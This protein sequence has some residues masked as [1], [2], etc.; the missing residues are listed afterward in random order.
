[1]LGSE[2]TWNARR[3]V[4]II[5]VGEVGCSAGNNPVTTVLLATIESLVGQAH[6]FRGTTGVG[7]K[8]GDSATDG[9]LATG[10]CFLAGEGEAFDLA[11][12]LLCCDECSFLVRIMEDHQELLATE[13]CGKII[14]ADGSFH[15]TAKL[16]QDF[17]AGQ[18]SLCIVV[19]LEVINIEEEHR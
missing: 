4:F 13:A 16:A 14:G 7:G 6:Q 15:D 2:P 17:I 11:A 8:G 12:H 18:M 5:A 19:V 1:V 9:Q 10:L 3:T